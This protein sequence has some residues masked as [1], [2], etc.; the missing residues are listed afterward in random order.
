MAVAHSL[1]Q[2]LGLTSGNAE[3]PSHSADPT[4]RKAPPAKRN[5]NQSIWRT[6]LDASHQGLC[7]V[8]LLDSRCLVRATWSKRAPQD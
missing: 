5:R 3:K 7:G 2:R 4:E 6:W 1:P 8:E